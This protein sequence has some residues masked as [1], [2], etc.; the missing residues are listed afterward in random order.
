MNKEQLDYEIDRRLSLIFEK[1]K[2]NTV[3][4]LSLQSPVAFDGNI[5]KLLK[6]M[7]ALE[8]KE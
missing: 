4:L 3:Y 2:V 8:D 7:L 1:I 5:D 6:D